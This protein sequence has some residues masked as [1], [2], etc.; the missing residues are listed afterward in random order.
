MVRLIPLY[1]RSLIIIVTIHRMPHCW[2]TPFWEKIPV[3][4]FV[5]E[6]EIWCVVR[7]DADVGFIPDALIRGF[8]VIR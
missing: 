1:L 7:V 8:Q 5:M 3:V 6:G 4:T 2:E